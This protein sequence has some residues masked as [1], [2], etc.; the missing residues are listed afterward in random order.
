VL[1]L[2][3]KAATTTS[4][5]TT[6]FDAPGPGVVR[7]AG[8]SP[9]TR[10][11]LRATGLT[12]CT[13]TKTITEA[14]PTTITCRL[15]NAAKRA[16]TQHALTVTLT[17]TFTPT[18]GTPLASTKTIRLSRTPAKAHTPTTTPGNVTG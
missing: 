1:P 17:T 18:S 6:T 16:R 5:I 11:H 2:A 10:S 12:V 13:T 9:S 4:T 8:T 7:Q 14:G 3:S 15:T